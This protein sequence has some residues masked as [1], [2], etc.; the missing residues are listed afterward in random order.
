[1][2]RFLIFLMGVL[3]LAFL[4][5]PMQA[6]NEYVVGY[7]DEE[8]PDD[9]KPVSLSESEVRMSAAIRLPANKL[10]RYKGCQLTK[11]RF[12]VMEG[13]QN[14]SVWAR[15][16]L[17]TSS[18][19]VQSVPEV[20]TGWNEVTLNK[21]LV[22][23][24]EDLFIGYTATQPA[25]FWGILAY[26]E[27]NEYTSWLAV[28]NEWNDYH[29]HG[30][31]ILFIQG[32]VEG[33]AYDN[34]VAMMDLDVDQNVLT[35]EESVQIS[36]TVVNTGTTSIGGCQLWVRIDEGAEETLA[37]DALLIPEQTATFTHT[38]QL[39][40]LEEGRHEVIVQVDCGEIGDMNPDSDILRIPI[41]IYS[42]SSPRTMLLEHFTSLPCVNCPPV[43]E[44]LEEALEGRT[45]VAWVTHH[46]G[47]REDEFTLEAS[48]NLTNFG[49]NGNP[50][51]MVDRTV[52]GGNETPAFTVST[53]S[54]AELEQN[55]FDYAV[56][57]PAFLQL[58]ATA[59]AEQNV[60]TI[61]VEGE[62]KSW[63]T[64]LFPKA[65]LHLFLVEDHVKSTKPQAGSNGKMI[66]DNILRAFITPTR[67]V[68]PTWDEDA[69]FSYETTFN[70]QPEWNQFNM[71]VVAFIVAQA[72][73]GTNYPSGKVLNATQTDMTTDIPTA[74][75]VLPTACD[76][77]PQRHSLYDLQGRP[78]NGPSSK[79][80][81]IL[82]GEETKKVFIP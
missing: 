9:M 65:T 30:L 20:V 23:D 43:D 55:V 26:G 71:R 33:I 77:V 27:G 28:G 18:K 81:Y 78:V 62:G 4:P 36:G 7:C 48:R 74:I 76:A 57:L 47:Y 1:M 42:S 50:Y 11:I 37:L 51:I 72:E 3:W 34:D 58:N 63:F 31:G 35:P 53:Y 52:L 69:H 61:D 54:V 70:L 67:G 66:H 15:T 25:S 41:Y 38:L 24:G 39:A 44:K 56:S 64:E 5:S 60:L 16:S 14:V 21:P 75:P 6:Q 68:M 82:K 45:D 80:V 22:I 32:V 10:M 12:A 19:V 49:V 59:H 73:A 79:G 40:S 29:D 13:F 17:T 8:L 46:V 2:N